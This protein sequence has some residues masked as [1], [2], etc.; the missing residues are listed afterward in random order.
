MKNLKQNIIS[1]ITIALSFFFTLGILYVAYGALA[2]LPAKVWTGS[3]LLSTDWNNMVD[4]LTELDGKISSNSIPTWFIWSFYL[5]SCPSGWILA[6]WANSTPDLRGKFLRA[7]V[8]STTYDPDYATRSWWLGGTNKVG[9]TQVE[10]IKNHRHYANPTNNSLVNWSADYANALL[11]LDIQSTIRTT[12]DMVN[13]WSET[14]PRNVALLYCM[15][16]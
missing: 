8:T 3:W 15:K 1:W 7:N 6:D 12:W 11:N 9:S 2:N 4:S 5:T 16:Q 14:R 13:W 10:S